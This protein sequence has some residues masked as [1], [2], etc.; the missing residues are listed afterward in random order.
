[1]N[2][3][4]PVTSMRMLTCLTRKPCVLDP[5]Q[6]RGGGTEELSPGLRH[7]TLTPASSMNTTPHGLDRSEYPFAAMRTNMAMAVYTTSMKAKAL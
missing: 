2:M 5:G 1:M 4:A 7:P 3:S 6:V